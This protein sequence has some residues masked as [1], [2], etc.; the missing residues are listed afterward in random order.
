H[1]G[2]L[3]GEATTSAHSLAAE[4][5]LD[6]PERFFERGGPLLDLGAHGG[7]LRL[8]VAEPALNDEAAL[9]DGRQGAHLLRHQYGV[10][11]RQQE[12]AAGRLIAPLREQT[13]G[14]WNVLVVGRRRR[15]V[16]AHEK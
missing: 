9:G 8:P 12:E 2:V 4:Q 11:E 7:E 14:D 3:E 5:A 16:V 13:P 10:P 6:D 15:V 1:H